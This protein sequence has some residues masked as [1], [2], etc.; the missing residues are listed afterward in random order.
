MKTLGDSDSEDDALTW[1]E[2]SR[3]KQ[4]EKEQAA[5]TVHDS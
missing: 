5:K 4:Q 2:K 1:V 3:R